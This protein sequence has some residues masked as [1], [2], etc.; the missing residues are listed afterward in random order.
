MLTGRE[1]E[2]GL[3]DRIM[4][5]LHDGHGRALFLTGESGIG[6]SSLLVALDASA[7]K[8]GL[9]VGDLGFSAKLRS[10]LPVPRGSR[11]LSTWATRSFRMSGPSLISVAIPISSR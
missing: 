8:R 6:K 9:R 2:L 3:F 11:S 4:D 5:D 7:L 1:R 10:P